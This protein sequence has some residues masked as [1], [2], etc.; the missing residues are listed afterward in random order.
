MN[1]CHV[2]IS[3]Q[4]SLGQWPATC[5]GQ[6][7]T[8]RYT[9]MTQEHASRRQPKDKLQRQYYFDSRSKTWGGTRWPVLVLAKFRDNNSQASIF[10]LILL[11]NVKM[12]LRSAPK[13]IRKAFGFIFLVYCCV[14]FVN[15]LNRST[16]NSD[17]SFFCVTSRATFF[18][19]RYRLHKTPCRC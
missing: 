5:R 10:V 3:G 14:Y 17:F 7:F 2:H 1:H 4:V 16:G 19:L 15:F 11:E 18:A 6:S 12:F 13:K 8:T 9:R